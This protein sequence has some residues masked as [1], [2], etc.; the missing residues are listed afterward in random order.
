MTLDEAL[1]IVK[2]RYGLQNSYVTAAGVMM[3]VVSAE[4]ELRAIPEVKLPESGIALL[5]PE[6]ID[7]ARG[8]IT[9]EALV[10][11]KNPKL[12]CI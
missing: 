6:V 10:R 8:A 7:L 12:F 1:E 11:R 9:V 4:R 2:E 5:A 3:H